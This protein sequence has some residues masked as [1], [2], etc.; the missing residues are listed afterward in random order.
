MS[1]LVSAIEEY[2]AAD[3]AALPSAVQLADLEELLV[4][5]RRLTAEIGRRLAAAEATDAL[6]V[7]TGY[8]PRSWLIADMQHSGGEASGRLKTA[9]T[10]ARLPNVGRAFAAGDIGA[11]HVRV[12]GKTLTEIPAGADRDAAVDWFQ[13]SV[14]RPDVA[15]LTFRGRGQCAAPTP[16]AALNRS[17]S[18]ST[19]GAVGGWGSV[20]TQSISSSLT[21]P[22]RASA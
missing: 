11:E 15:P 7:E 2:A 3:A 5:E 6:V 13:R 4:A 17:T 14:S 20:S 12:L 22:A 10:C 19:R 1:G 18:S 21:A 8:T 9:R 16:V